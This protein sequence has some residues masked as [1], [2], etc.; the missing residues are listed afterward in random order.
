MR[1][2]VVEPTSKTLHAAY[3][4]FF[5]HVCNRL[6]VCIGCFFFSPVSNHCTAFS[7]FFSR[8]EQTESELPPPP[9]RAAATP[10][11]SAPSRR[12]HRQHSMHNVQTHVSRDDNFTRG[13]GY[14]Q[15]SDPLDSGS[16]TK[17]NPRVSPIPDP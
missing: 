7:S 6:A 17:F 14:P 9:T 11:G 12:M 2:G 10:P 4:L 3:Y 15:I 16:G 1:S 13:F 8:L 5:S